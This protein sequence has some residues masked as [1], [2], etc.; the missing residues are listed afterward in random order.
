MDTIVRTHPLGD[1]DHAEPHEAVDKTTAWWQKTLGVTAVLGQASN[2]PSPESR[3]PTANLLWTKPGEHHARPDPKVVEA[4]PGTAEGKGPD[5]PATRVR[6]GDRWSAGSLAAAR[7]LKQR[8]G[9]IV[10]DAVLAFA[11]V[12]ITFLKAVGSVID[13]V[14]KI[15]AV[16]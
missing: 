5:N 11:I 14:R 2:R 15:P 12:F 13:S 6:E 7:R 3:T 8:F 16:R 9:V 10:R 1:Q 4:N